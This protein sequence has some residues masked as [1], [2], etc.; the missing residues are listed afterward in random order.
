[1]VTKLIAAELATSAGCNMI[2]SIGTEPQRIIQI[3]NEISEQADKGIF[4][5]SIGTHFIKKEIPLGGRSW[6]VLSGLASYGSLIIDKG[7]VNALTRKHKSSLFPAGI[8]N[9]EG[10]FNSQQCVRIV[11]IN[12][13]EGKQFEK[14]I[15]RGLVNYSSQEIAR[16]KG[17]QGSDIGKI[18]G[19]SESDFVI[20]RDNIALVDPKLP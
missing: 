14:E 10:T 6:W 15:A 16:I 2:I 4:E 20:H 3:I 11:T 17:C 5:P 13:V 7:A 19:Y 1:M 8:I 9:V 12:E 18:L